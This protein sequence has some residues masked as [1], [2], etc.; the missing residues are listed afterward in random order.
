MFIA[1]LLAAA[2]ITESTEDAEIGYANR[3]H[4]GWLPVIVKTPPPVGVP[5]YFG[6]QSNKAV[7]PL[8]ILYL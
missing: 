4:A 3:V 5:K 6:I 7:S 8:A 2:I 1:L